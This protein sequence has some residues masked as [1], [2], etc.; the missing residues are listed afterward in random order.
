MQTFNIQFSNNTQLLEFIDKSNILN[1]KN[2]L[3][4]IFSGILDEKQVLN[5]SA[6]L[7]TKIPHANIIGTSTA[8]EILNG[9]M[10][11]ET[12]L[13]SIT[14]F[15]STTLKSKLFSFEKEFKIEDIHKNLIS[16]NTKALI[17][18]SDGLKS[19]AEEFLKSLTTIT[20]N[21]IIAGGRAGDHI[22]YSKTFVFDHRQQKMVLL[23]QV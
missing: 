20:P 15:E 22:S 1:S 7:Q 14:T 9:T 8:R 2:I 10:Y 12:I 19:N 4:Q 11:E 13:I 17:V 3:I 6:L 21:I 23:S 16:K 18:F 5:V